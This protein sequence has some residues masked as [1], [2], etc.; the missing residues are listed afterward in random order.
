MERYKNGKIYRLIVGDEFYV[1]S[2]CSTLAKRKCK[3]KYK[4]KKYPDRK[5]Y[6]KA[7]EVGWDNINVVLIEEYPCKNKM[8]LVRRERYWV[9]ELQ[10]TLNTQTPSRT[11]KEWHEENKERHA[12]NC[13]KWREAHTE[14]EKTRKH[15][16]YQENKEIYL[17]RNKEWRLANKDKM[18]EYNKKYRE[19]KRLTA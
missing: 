17:Q 10:P 8:E 12:D 16:D 15:I 18:N 5:V 4:A 9:D 7:N 3:H 11:K 6:Q 1:G 13:K 14:E 19:R 2:T